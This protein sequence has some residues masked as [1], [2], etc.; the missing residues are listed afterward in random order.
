VVI[1][2]TP[3]EVTEYF[4]FGLESVPSVTQDFHARQPKEHLIGSTPQKNLYEFKI[5]ALKC[6]VLTVK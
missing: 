1:N 4:G 3:Q 5:G 6:V 2:G